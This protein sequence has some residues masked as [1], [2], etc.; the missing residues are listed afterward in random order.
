MIDFGDGDL[1]VIETINGQLIG[2]SLLGGDTTRL[3]DKIVFRRYTGASDAEK[4]LE[5]AEDT[6]VSGASTQ[7][8][9][10]KQKTD[11]RVLFMMQISLHEVDRSGVWSF[12]KSSPTQPFTL[13]H[14][15]TPNDDASVTSN[16]LRSFFKVGEYLFQSFI[17][18]GS[19][20][21]VTK[22][23]NS[24]GAY[25]ASSIYESTINPNLDKRYD[26]D[27]KVLK[28]FH[29]RYNALGSNGS[30]KAEYRVNGG[31]WEEIFTETTDDA[32]LTI[33]NKDV[34][35]KQFKKG[36]DFE[37]RLTSTGGAEITEFGAV[38]ETEKQ[39]VGTHT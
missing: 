14:E 19:T 8:L 37:Y 23:N 39:L 33:Q 7:L 1:K 12:G 6:S 22:T 17:E 35:G 3:Q 38:Y 15:S 27:E 18:G 11:G 30:V 26:R 31:S 28:E 2:I 24:S 29:C 20:F 25:T 34:N 21:T 4:L 9:S 13:I 36:I 5:L 10:I 32:L 16:V